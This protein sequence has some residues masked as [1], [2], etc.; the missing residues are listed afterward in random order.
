LVEKIRRR[1]TW[2]GPRSGL[3]GR[4]SPG[5]HHSEGESALVAELF[6]EQRERVETPGKIEVAGE[7]EDGLADARQVPRQ[8]REPAESGRQLLPAVLVPEV[9]G[10]RLDGAIVDAE[11]PMWVAPCGEEEQRAPSSLV[12]L[13]VGYV[14]LAARKIGD[15]GFCVAELSS[16]EPLE[17]VHHRV[18]LRIIA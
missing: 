4:V 3:F 11:I 13:R 1:A 14:D 18:H 10:E 8:Q 5:L 17:D 16:L 12:Q 2:S 7:Y 6:R 15:D 9:D